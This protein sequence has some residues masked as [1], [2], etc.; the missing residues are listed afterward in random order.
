MRNGGLR[1][2]DGLHQV[3]GA[4]LV[5]LGPGD[6]R[7]KPQT[8]GVSQDL[9]GG[10]E[11]LG[12]GFGEPAREE[13][14]A[15]LLYL[16]HC[17]SLDCVL[18]GNIL[19]AVDV[20]ATVIFTTVDMTVPSKELPVS[21]IQLALSV[22]D[23]DEAVDFYS[24]LF[25]TPPAKR[26]P[27]YA[28]F[29]IDEPPLKLVLIHD[30]A[31]AGQMNHLGVEVFSTDEV[32]AAARRL[33]AA[34][35]STTEESGACCYADQQKVWVDDPDGAPWEIYTVLADADTLS[36]AED[37]CCSGEREAAACCA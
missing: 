33:S 36:P 30:P 26:L 18:N 32:S 23:V 8:S 1:L 2:A 6:H 7:Q 29:A 9:E 16:F 37:G 17:Y 12:V 14:L 11:V 34:G 15:A 10:G 3:A 4:H 25:A 20:P 31:R 24:K 22:S 21:R 5:G 28:N 27:G 13:W 35:V 19:T